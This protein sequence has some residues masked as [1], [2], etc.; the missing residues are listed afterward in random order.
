MIF[1]LGHIRFLM[2]KLILKIWDCLLLMKSR[3][4]VLF[5]RKR[6]RNIKVLLMFLLCLLR[7]FQELY[8]CQC[9]VLEVLRLLKHLRKKENLY[10]LM[11]FQKIRILL[12][13]LYIRNYLEMG[14]YLFYL[15]IL[16]NWIVN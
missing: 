2:I 1:Y 9:L 10:K 5:I 12:R 3:D 11:L 8:K 7:Q 14:R 4:L 16:I 13:M 6:L 15:M